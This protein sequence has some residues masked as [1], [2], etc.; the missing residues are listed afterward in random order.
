M[1]KLGA[2]SIC[3]LVKFLHKKDR[4][5]LLVQG[6][7]LSTSSNPAMVFQIPS[8]SIAAG[9]AILIYTTGKSVGSSQ[10]GGDLLTSLPLSSNGGSV[11]LL[12]GSGNIASA[13]QYPR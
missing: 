9:A 13:V 11:I 10:A 6:Y 5:F 1:V 7:S 3:Y 12:D 2:V 4:K 8:T